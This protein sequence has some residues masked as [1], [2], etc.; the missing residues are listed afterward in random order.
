M[1]WVVPTGVG[2]LGAGSGGGPPYSG[3]DA[4]ADVGRHL[5]PRASSPQ[6]LLHRTPASNQPSPLQPPQH[7]PHFQS[8]QPQPQPQPLY[9]PQPHALQSPQQQQ[10][11]LQHQHQH[12]QQANQTQGPVGSSS[13]LGRSPAARLAGSGSGITG[14]PVL[15]SPS[16]QSAPQQQIQQPW[17]PQQQQQTVPKLLQQQQ[18]LQLQLQQQQLLH[19]PASFQP[20]VQYQAEP[21]PTPAAVQVPQQVHSNGLGAPSEAAS[22]QSLQALL[23]SVPASQL[24]SALASVLAKVIRHL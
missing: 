11:S 8:R 3:G 9:R 21:Q 4:A 20:A 18:Q 24:H 14:S 13:S 22:V 7:M 16:Q 12:Q 2:S 23:A 10:Q 1:P 6:G 5:L 17:Q 15:P 19:Q